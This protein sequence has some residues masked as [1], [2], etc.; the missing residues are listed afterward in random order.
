MDKKVIYLTTEEIDIVKKAIGQFLIM[1]KSE[2]IKTDKDTIQKA[3][4]LWDNF[5]NKTLN[6]SKTV[7]EKKEAGDDLKF[8]DN[9]YGKVGE[10]Y[11]E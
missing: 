2:F 6:V 3:Q 10:V 4:Q 8:K 7:E 1:A 5:E 11:G 9:P